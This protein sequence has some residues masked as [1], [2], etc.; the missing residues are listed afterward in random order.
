M[1]GTCDVSSEAMSQSIR[2]KKMSVNFARL[3]LLLLVSFSTT[4]F[5]AQG[6]RP[7]CAM[8]KGMDLKAILGADH[9]APVPFGQESCRAES[10]SP[11]KIV[12]LG[13]MQGTAAEHQKMF[14]MI[15]KIN[16]GQRAKEVKVVA[17]PTLGKDA[18]SIRENDMR[19]IEIMALKGDRA[20][21]LQGGI[22]K[23]LDDAGVKQFVGLAKAAL[24]KLP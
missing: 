8:L 13:L 11:G 14:A 4:L 16:S 20:I 15:R 24:D 2:E 22:G 5:A 6:E 19:Q 17:E 12:I 10:K 7:A 9:D 18:F 3:I 21:S 1:R 23:P